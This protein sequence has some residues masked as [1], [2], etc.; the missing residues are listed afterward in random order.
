MSPLRCS[1]LALFAG[2]SSPTATSPLRCPSTALINLLRV[3]FICY[4]YRR[5]RQRCRHL[6]RHSA[7]STTVVSLRAVQCQAE[8]H[9]SPRSY[10]VRAALVGF[11]YFSSSSNRYAYRRRRDMRISPPPPQAIVSLPHSRSSPQRVRSD[12]FGSS[13]YHSSQEDAGLIIRCQRTQG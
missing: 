4:A 6:G 8:V 12:C 2:Q 7:T 3:L 10:P 11:I 9:A 13:L 5:R 1:T